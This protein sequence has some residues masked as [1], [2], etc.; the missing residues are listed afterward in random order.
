[1]SIVGHVSWPAHDTFLIMTLLGQRVY[2]P[3][4]LRPNSNLQKLVSCSCHIRELGQTLTLLID[5][6]LMVIISLSILLMI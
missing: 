4:P 5:D 6:V 1:M 3:N 2:N